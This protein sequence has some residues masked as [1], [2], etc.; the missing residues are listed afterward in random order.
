MPDKKKYTYE[1]LKEAMEA[2]SST[3]GKIEKVSKNG[4]LGAS[5]Q[6]L[7]MRRLKAL[8]IASELIMEKIRDVE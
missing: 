5:Q 7:I 1:V 8:R 4:S 3:I 6:T 2:I